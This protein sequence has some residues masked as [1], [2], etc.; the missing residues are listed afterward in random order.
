MCAKIIKSNPKNTS[1]WS[2]G[3]TTELLMYPSESSYKNRD[4]EYRLSTAKVEVESSVLLLCPVF[5]ES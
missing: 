4:F 2:G 1:K 3:D 5:P